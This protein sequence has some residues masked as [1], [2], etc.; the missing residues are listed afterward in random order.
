MGFSTEAVVVV[1]GLG[2]TTVAGERE[3]RGRE[4]GRLVKLR[5]F[6]KTPSVFF[7]LS[8]R[9]DTLLVCRETEGAGMRQG[10]GDE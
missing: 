9:G 7:S 6:M 5:I 2:E 3:R 10:E 8:R 1:G 4:G